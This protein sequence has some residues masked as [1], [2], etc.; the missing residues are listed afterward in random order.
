M[1]SATANSST[2]TRFNWLTILATLGAIWYFFGLVQ[3]WLAYTMDP[4]AAAAAGTITQDHADALATT[5]MFVWV[6]FAS[7]SGMGLLGAIQLLRRAKSAALI[8]ALSLASA[9]SYYTWIFAISDTGFAYPAEMGI[10]GSVVIAITIVFTWIA[11][12]NT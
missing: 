9:V 8:F 5:P 12:R 1:N 11:K 4:S 10:I 2:A 7:A 6:F 3:F